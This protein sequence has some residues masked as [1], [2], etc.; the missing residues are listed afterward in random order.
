MLDQD[1]SPRTTGNTTNGMST[2]TAFQIHFVSPEN[3]QIFLA[4]GGFQKPKPNYAAK[5]QLQSPIILP[6]NN[7]TN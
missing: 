3:N 4:H 7:F 6:Y 2:P 5:I 1:E